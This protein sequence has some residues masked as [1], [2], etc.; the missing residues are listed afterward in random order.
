MKNCPTCIRC[1]IFLWMALI[2]QTNSVVK[3]TI[4]F[5]R[6]TQNNSVCAKNNDQE[7]ANARRERQRSVIKLVDRNSLVSS[8]ILPV[9][10]F[11]NPNGNNEK[12]SPTRL[13]LKD[14]PGKHSL[15]LHMHKSYMRRLYCVFVY[16]YW[17]KSEHW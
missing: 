7:G 9:N 17:K 14:L 12:W 3:S 10:S 4:L 1:V 5:M 2:N 8:F 6:R 13:P 11:F 15:H 16:G